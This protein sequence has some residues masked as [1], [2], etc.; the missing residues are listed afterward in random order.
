M[1]LWDETE[2]QRGSIEVCSVLWDFLC[3]KLENKEIQ[4]IHSFSDG[5]S[6]Q[7]RNKNII[8]I[9]TRVAEEYG[10]SWTHSFL[11]SGHTFLPNDQEFGKISE[12]KACKHLIF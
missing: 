12:K 8:S 1:H 6:G 7:N 9:M 5:C 10:V 2:G 3:K 11:E 4:H